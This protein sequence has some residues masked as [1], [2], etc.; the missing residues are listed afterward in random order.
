MNQSANNEIKLKVFLDYIASQTGMEEKEVAEEMAVALEA[1]IAKNGH[2]PTDANIH[3]QISA[4]T[5]LLEIFREWEIVNSEDIE[6]IERQ[7]SI[8]DARELSDEISLG[9][10]LYV[11]LP[12]EKLGRVAAQQ[13]KQLFSKIIRDGQREQKKNMLASQIGSIVTGV[14][15]RGKREFILVETSDQINAIIYRKNL[16]AREIFRENDKITALIINNDPEYKGAIIEL[17]RTAN[18]FL[19]KL[20]ANE[21]PEIHEGSIEI[22]ATARDPG[23][24][25]KIAVKSNDKR[26]DPIGACIGMRGTRVQ[27]V[28]N[29]LNGERIDV[30]LWNEDPA[31]MVVQALSPGVIESIEINEENNSMDLNVAN[32][33]LA[34]VIGKNGQNIK[35]A[36]ELSGWKLDI[37]KQTHSDET[38][39]ERLIEYLDVDQDIA[40]LLVKKHYASPQMIVHAGVEKISQIDEFDEDIASTLVERAQDALLAMTLSGD[41][42]IEEDLPL[43]QLEQINL[44]YAQMLKDKQIISLDDLAE[45][46]VDELIEL[47]PLDRQT[48]SSVIMKAREPWFKDN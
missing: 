44:E 26:V 18:E 47:I 37:K 5:G 32:E 11:P 14:V 12:T 38:L 23:Y 27:A 25:A 17:S 33:N 41:E 8:E 28:T 13:A 7:M 20:F 16:I 4:Q 24:R 36:S 9:Q 29:E 46:S 22:K 21:V 43:L 3:V 6:N 31:T 42:T 10:S 45:L 19:T 2:Y 35:L 39:T 34:K 15:R 30:I 1:V 40:T 48:A